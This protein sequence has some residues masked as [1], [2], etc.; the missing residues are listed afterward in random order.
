MVTQAK[1]W[2]SVAGGWQCDGCGAITPSYSPYAH[3]CPNNKHEACTNLVRGH[4]AAVTA[5][6]TADN[7]RWKARHVQ[8]WNRPTRFGERATKLAI[9]SY[10]AYAD[11]YYNSFES[12]I[13]EDGYFGDHARNMLRAVSA[14]LSMAFS[15]RLDSGA[16]HRLL[17]Q[18]AE[19]S[20]IDPDGI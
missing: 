7:P 9:E 10:A 15:S 16:V 8:H 12:P 6:T 1:G 13:G 3:A 18:L 4:A 20:G 14:S 19:A 5:S 11:D 2:T 17:C